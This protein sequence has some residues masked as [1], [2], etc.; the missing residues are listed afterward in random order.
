[1]FQAFL[2]EI[3]KFKCEEKRTQTDGYWEAVASQEGLDLFHK[4]LL[5][6]FGP[7]L[8][9]E[10]QAPSREARRYAEPYGGVRKDQ[11]LYFRRDGEHSECALLW[12]W[13]NGTR[14]TI[15]VARSKSPSPE[16]GLLRFFSILVGRK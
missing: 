7:P 8:K 4:V 5:A 10:G 16:T 9:P 6:Y 11:T 13:G 12:P 14:F 1:M 15:K 2:A 3:Q